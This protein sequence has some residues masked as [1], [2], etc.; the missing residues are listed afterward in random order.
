MLQNNSKKLNKGEIQRTVDKIRKKYEEYTVRFLKSPKLK[1]AFEQ[2]YAGVLR[3]SLDIGSFLSAEIGVIEEL[4][5]KEMSKLKYSAA[6]AE[7]Q[8]KSQKDR[9][10]FADKILEEHKARI[11]KYKKIDFH[12]DANNEVSRLL[13]ALNELYRTYTPLMQDVAKNSANRNLRTTDIME[14]ESRLR[15]MGS[16]DTDN[17]SSRLSRYYAL[18][19][20]FPRDYKAIDHEEKSF[21]LDSAFLLHD[22]LNILTISETNE[23]RV[24]NRDEDDLEKIIAYINK[25]IDDFRLKD[26]KRKTY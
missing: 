18:L 12:K 23:E 22:F 5:K 14:M 2:R 16:L 11:E 26:L 7:K 17:V 25:V 8:N 3:K 9:K 4:I 21:I 20:R 6:Q 19:N 24:K 10:N 13:G 1:Y 15:V